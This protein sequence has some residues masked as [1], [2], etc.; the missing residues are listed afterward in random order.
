MKG[1]PAQKMSCLKIS[2]CDLPDLPVRGISEPELH[3]REDVVFRRPVTVGR[4]SIEVRLLVI[5][6]ELHGPVHVPIEPRR[7]GARGTGRGSRIREEGESV[8]VRG[9]LVITGR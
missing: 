2:S 5:G 9:E 7:P 8:A 3:A 1:L 6:A 4:A